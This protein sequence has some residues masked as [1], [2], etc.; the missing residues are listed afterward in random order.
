MAIT[1]FW[2]CEGATL[3]GTDDLPGADTS[4]TA[5]GAVAINGTAALVGSNGIQSA[6][7]GEHY[8]LD[9]EAAVIDPLAGSLAFWFRVQTWVQNA[10]LIYLGGTSGS[11]SI[12]IA[13][14]GNGAPTRNLRLRIETATGPTAINLDLAGSLVELNTTYFATASWDNAANDRRVRL[15]DSSGTL[16]DSTEDTSTSYTAPTELVATDKLRIGEAG[17]FASAFYIDNV[18]IGKAY[19][20]A[21]TFLTNRSITS[22]TQYGGTATTIT[23]L[24]KRFQG[25]TYRQ[26]G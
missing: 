12:H 20:D 2:R 23:G 5:N 19:A 6:T 25:W 22:Y 13:L 18:F 7:S 24:G 15:Y 16:L 26:G 3:S 8:R 9:A 17:G 10:I 11:N 21:D 14:A 1:F 4:A